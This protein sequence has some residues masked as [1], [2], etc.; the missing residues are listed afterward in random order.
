MTVARR[1]VLARRPVGTV[2]AGHFRTEDVDVPP[3]ADGQALL[4]TLW[5]SIDPSIRGWLDDRPSY[6][7]PVQI[8]ETVRSFGLAEVIESRHGTL[9]VGDVVRGLVGWQELQVSDRDDWVTVPRD[10]APLESRL[11]VLGMTGLTA[12]VGMREIARPAPGETVLVS[13]AAGAVGS[14]AAQLARAAGARVVGIAGGPDKCRL[15]STGSASTPRS[16]TGRPT[17]PGSSRT[18]RRTAST[19]TSRT[20]A[21]EPW[22]SRSSG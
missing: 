17:G 9:R 5:I 6:L 13:A 18:R 20:S 8:D 7:P 10:G 22:S 2:T 15:R 1:V 21:A 11:G 4:R 16:T 12:W 19:S 3:P 14:V